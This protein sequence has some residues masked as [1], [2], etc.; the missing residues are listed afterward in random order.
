MREIKFRG[1]KVSNEKWVYGF[2]FINA[3]L[4]HMIKEHIMVMKGRW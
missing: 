4:E 1:K 3:D 2:V